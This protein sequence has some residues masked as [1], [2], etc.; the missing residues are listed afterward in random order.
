MFNVLP[1]YVDSHGLKGGAVGIAL[2]ILVY[3]LFVIGYTIMSIGGASTIS[4]ALTNDPKQRPFVTFI[5]TTYQRVG[6]MLMNTILAFT[7]L[8]K[9]NNEYNVAPFE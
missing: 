6:P 8:P 4:S 3:A 2:F 7:I 9:H 5:T 1:H